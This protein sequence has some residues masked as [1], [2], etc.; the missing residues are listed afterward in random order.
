[1]MSWSV[2]KRLALASGLVAVAWAL[3]LLAMKS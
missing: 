3:I 1:M 2:S